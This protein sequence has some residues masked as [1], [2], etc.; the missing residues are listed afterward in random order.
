GGLPERIA[1]SGAQTLLELRR[2]RLQ[3]LIRSHR[4]QLESDGSGQPVARGRLVAI[5]PD[6]ASLQLA[7]RAGFFILTEERHGELGLRVVH[8]RVPRG[9][10]A[11][12]ALK[13]LRSAAP[14]IEADFDHLFEPAGG[15]LLPVAGALAAAATSGPGRKIGM[16]DGG[17]ASHPSL[18]RAPIEQNGFSG[19]PQPTGHGTAV[20][21]LIVGDQGPFRGAARGSSLLVADV[22]G[23]SR[24]AGS[25]TAVVR[26]L[27]WLARHRPSVI[28]I[29]LVGPSNRLVARAV[30]AVRAR[31]I[32]LVAAVGNDGPAAPP[33][34]PASYPGVVA[35]TG[36]DARGRALPEA[37]RATHVDFAAPGADMAAAL[38]GEGYAKV[39]GTSFAAPLAA[40]R[41]ALVGSPQ[42]LVAEAR[43]GKGRVGRGIVCADCRVAPKAVRAK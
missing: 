11:R 8:L 39:R 21:S 9:M 36:V 28:N 33:Q 14:R 38:P 19:S 23:G 10:S 32:Q 22:Y 17:V 29:S 43:P 42:R 20:A 3:E 18:A 7:A 25:A 31:G 41:L 27:A 26:A 1:E 13:R 34:Y 16:I 12:D 37:G 4:G 15:E 30:G 6:P 2:L 5:D 40:A 35:V 24:A